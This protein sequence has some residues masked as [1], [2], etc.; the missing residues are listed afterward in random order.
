MI[1]VSLA[2]V[3]QL[4]VSGVVVGC[5]YA[6]I[7]LGFNVIFNATGLINFAQGEFVLFGGFFLYTASILLDL[8][9]VPALLLAIAAVSV[10]GAS[11][12]L[13]VIR[14]ARGEGHIGAGASL[15]GVSLLMVAIAS[16][17]WGADPLP[18][19]EFTP[20]EP[21]RL[22]DVLITRQQLW[23]IGVTIVVVVGFQLFFQRT[24]L[25]VAMRAAAQNADAARGS[26][27]SVERMSLMAFIIG[28]ALAALGG[29]L[30]T[31]ILG[32]AAYGGLTLVLKGFTAAMLGGLGDPRGAVIGGLA[33]GLV[34]QVSAAF[35][36]S[37]Y[38]EAVPMAMLILVL[39]LRP[40]GILGVGVASRA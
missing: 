38:Q 2:T 36:S 33:L 12:Q 31:P 13:G 14:F 35:I 8:P 1:A 21:Y 6:L 26:G 34:E 29:V 16:W 24:S 15:I 11:V 40:G 4:A 28:A 25:G 30:I 37:G 22:G 5:V 18:V 39:M 7:A 32:V 9:L 23:V 17:A 27:I 10:I 20:G 3:E 19:R